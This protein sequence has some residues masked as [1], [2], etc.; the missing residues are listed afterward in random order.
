MSLDKKDEGKQ[1]LILG[2]SLQDASCSCAID[3]IPACLIFHNFTIQN[4]Q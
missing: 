4:D 1:A 2:E 3:L